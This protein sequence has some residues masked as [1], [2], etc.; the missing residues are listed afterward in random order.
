MIWVF[1]VVI[2]LVI[3]GIAVVAAGGGDAL[4]PTYDDR[5][6]VLVP[7]AGALG[8]DDLRRLRFTSA[9]RGYRASEVDALLERL[10]A[11]LENQQ[12]DQHQRPT[13]EE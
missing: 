1:A 12:T 8:A 2:V 3:G 11:Q 10:A 4:A 13:S 5:P 7:E 9:L 6:D